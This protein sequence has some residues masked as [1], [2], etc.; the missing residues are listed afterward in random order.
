M[1]AIFL[2]Q[3]AKYLNLSREGI[4]EKSC[5]DIETAIAEL[6]AKRTKV[7][8]LV[9]AGTFDQ[10]TY[11]TQTQAIRTAITAKEQELASKQTDAGDFEDCIEYCKNFLTNARQIW[12][13]GDIHTQK[14]FQ[15]TLFPAGFTITPEKV[16]TADIPLLFKVVSRR[17]AE[18]EDARL[19]A[20][21][22]HLPKVVDLSGIEPLTSCMAHILYQVSNISRP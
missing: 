6:R 16:G 18:K 10:E 20:S 7:E 8:D 13:N 9:I 4:H 5:K 1:A 14:R 3:N 15:A 11:K 12:E 22:G 2:S 17:A 19:S 21:G